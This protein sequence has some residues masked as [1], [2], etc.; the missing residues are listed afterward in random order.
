MA[1][2][3]LHDRR[4]IEA[5][6]ARM[7]TAAIERALDGGG[8]S[9]LAREA[10][11]EELARRVLADRVDYGRRAARPRLDRAASAIVLIVYLA[12]LGALF[13]LFR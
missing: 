3:N 12:S 11:A 13:G 1:I 6:V 10:V 4:A 8:L 2:L 9:A 7:D 5:T